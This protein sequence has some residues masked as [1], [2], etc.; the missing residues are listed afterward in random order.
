M[1]SPCQFIEVIL[2]RF[3]LASA[4]ILHADLKPLANWCTHVAVQCAFC[5]P[6]RARNR[7]STV[8][9]GAIY[10][11]LL[12]AGVL[13]PGDTMNESMLQ[14]LQIK[15]AMG[16]EG[17]LNKTAIATALLLAL[18]MGTDA[19]SLQDTTLIQEALGLA[20]REAPTRS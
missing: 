13:H 10:W 4:S 14:A 11:F 8:S 6:L 12:K 2:S 3:S 9:R 20:N 17:Q 15:N 18:G 16:K 1:T 5:G 19:S 7:P